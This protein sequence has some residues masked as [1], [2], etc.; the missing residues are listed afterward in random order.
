MISCPY[1]RKKL[2]Q[3][4]HRVNDLAS[5]ETGVVNSSKEVI[6]EE[7]ELMECTKEGCGVWHD[8]K[9]NYQVVQLNT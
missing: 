7:Y 9:C 3:V 5:E 6:K 8:G 2:T 1:N 4:N